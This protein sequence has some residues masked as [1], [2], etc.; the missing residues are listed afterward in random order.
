MNIYHYDS[1][2]AYLQEALTQSRGEKTQLALFLN[3]QA[4]FISQVLTGDKTHF[5]LE[6]IKRIGDFLMLEKEELDF[7][8]LLCLYERAG[9]KE[10]QSHFHEK[11]KEVQNI[12][13]QIHRKIEKRGQPL[14][15]EQKAT[16]YSHWSFMAIHMMVSIPTLATNEKIRSH[17]NLPSK[18]VDEVL[19]FLLLCDLIEKHGS[20]YVI[21]KT[22]LHLE[23]KSPFIKSLH[24]NWRH[25][26]IESLADENELNMHYSSVLVL[27]KKDALKIKE[28]ILDFIKRKE[29]ILAPSP[30]E[31]LVAFNMDY[32]KL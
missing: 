12:H 26:A 32:F 9:S 22:R 15:D 25:K 20:R 21:G 5:S 16:Y 2:K 3:C 6:H 24:Q 29:Q 13:Q 17:F 28:M 7:L 14:T 27:S 31:Q 10:L 11:I 23:K 18:F 8:I 30:E 19:D 1:Y 4:S